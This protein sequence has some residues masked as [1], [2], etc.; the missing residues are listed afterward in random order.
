MG[1]NGKYMFPYKAILDGEAT[2]SCPTK[3]AVGAAMDSLVHAIEAYICKFSNTFSDM[4]SE[5]AIELIIPSILD[6]NA[7]KPNLEKRL[8]FIYILSIQCLL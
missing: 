1:I 6:L 7:T 5:K 3:P 4:L 8:I 2:L